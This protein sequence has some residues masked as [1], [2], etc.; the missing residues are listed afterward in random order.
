M[1]LVACLLTGV[2]AANAGDGAPPAEKTEVALA[3][4]TPDEVDKRIAAKTNDFFVYDVNPREVYD[5]GHV[6]TATWLPF[7]G[8]TAAALP[9]NKADTLV[10]YCANEH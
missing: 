3:T 1:W 5:A 6:P 8:V 9:A 10:F 2:P 7:D 4:L